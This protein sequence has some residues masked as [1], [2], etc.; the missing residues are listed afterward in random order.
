MV[1]VNQLFENYETYAE[2]VV[3]CGCPV[4]VKKRL[5]HDEY[6]QFVN[7]IMEY[8]KSS[9]DKNEFLPFRMLWRVLTINFYTNLCFDDDTYADNLLRLAYESD[10][11]EKIVGADGEPALINMTQYNDMLED[12]SYTLRQRWEMENNVRMA[13]LMGQSKEAE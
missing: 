2:D 10:L 11:Y 13:R 8:M 12:V 6:G 9:Y 7:T 4:I 5:T 3:V 1:T